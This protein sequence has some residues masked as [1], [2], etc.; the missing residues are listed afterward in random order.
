MRDPMVVLYNL[1]KQAKKD[2]YTFKRLY[3]NLYNE[4]FYLKA[5]DNI[6]AN[7]GSSTK[8]VDGQTA[9]GF[10]ISK[11]K[12]LIQK[13]RNEKYQPK[14]VKRVYIPKKNDKKRPLGI[15][16]FND[17]L[18]QE[19]VRMI[20]E[21]IYEE[22]F[23][24]HS[25]GFR[26]ARSCHTAL[27]E[28]KKEFT[29][30]NWFVEGDIKSFFDTIDHHILINILREKIKDEKFIR[31]IWKFLGAGYI[32]NWKYYGTYS[33][34]PQGGI[35]S[36][37]LANIYLDQLD[38]Y[39]EEYREK[40]KEG[41]PKSK[42]RNTEY[43]KYAT[44][45]RRLKKKYNPIWDKLNDKEKADI[46]N[47][48]KEWEK[49]KLSL[50]YYDPIHEGYKDIKYV[51]YADDFII[52]VYGSK[53]D[54][55]KIKKDLNNFLNKKLNIELSNEKTLITHNSKKASFLGYDISIM[56]DQRTFKNKRGHK[57]RNNN[58]RVALYMPQNRIKDYVVKHNLV[59]DVD[60]KDWRMLHRSKL[61][62][63]P[64]LEII[65]H[66]NAEIR[67]LYNYYRLAKNVSVYMWQFRHVMEY[68]CLATIAN[69]R[70]STISK[71]KTKL[72]N[73]EDWGIWYETKKG[74]K[75]LPFYNEGFKQVRDYQLNDYDSNTVDEYPNL[76]PYYNNTTSL[77]DRLKAYKCEMC[78][79]EDENKKY[80][81][82]HVNKLKNLKGKKKWEKI[83]I[84]KNRKTL[85]MCKECHDKL[86][87]GKLD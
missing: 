64:E 70:K 34:T 23:S 61:I 37:V 28:V 47:K 35:I 79:T 24:K 41:N 36:P 30:I 43:R 33:G 56:N 86:H 67:G 29:G 55:K 42:K 85:I 84:A 14:P 1:A 74:E 53:N 51:R 11:V 69:K 32:D 80:E 39:V 9:D 4:E 12:K 31:L 26:K 6:Y 77:V 60:S 16:T 76:Y 17:R 18:V 45:I 3:R 63:H 7:H 44:R 46:I 40:F 59:K 72:K 49:K 2:N 13:L 82:H 48:K 83:M 75:F 58:K 54:C 78:G 10:S 52:G 38:K 68:S 8:G 65:S 22:S 66:Y 5:Y 73:G 50:P 20:L 15:P 57:V 81:V 27:I 87:E 19:V 71:V 62:N 25:H 21:S